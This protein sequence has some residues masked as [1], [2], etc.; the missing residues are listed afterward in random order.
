MQDGGTRSFASLGPALRLLGLALLIAA[1]QAVRGLWLSLL[2]IQRGGAPFAPALAGALCGLAA[3]AAFAF[4]LRHA[5]EN[6]QALAGGGKL[7]PPLALA[8]L[9]QPRLEHPLRE[10]WARSNPAEAGAPMPRSRGFGGLLGAGLAIAV[11]LWACGLL[12]PLAG[13]VVSALDAVHHALTFAACVAGLHFAALLAQRQDD[14]WRQVKPSVLPVPLRV[15]GKARAQPVSPQSLPAS[16][17]ARGPAI[18]ARAV[19]TSAAA[20]ASSAPP[21]AISAPPPAISAP[22]PPPA[23]ARLVE[24]PAAPPT[25]CPI[26]GA[27]LAGRR[28]EACG[29]PALAASFRVLRSLGGGGARRTYLAEAP[30]G[31]RVVL[32]ELSIATAPDAQALDGFAREAR[33][34]RE[35]RHP[36]LPIYLDAFQEEEG[37]RARLYLAYRYLDGISLQQELEERR[38]SEDEVLELVEQVLEILRHLHCL[39][40]PLIHRDLKPANLVRRRDGAISLIDFGVARSLDRT[41]NSG[42]LAGT[43]G[44]M[45]PEQLAGQVDLTSDLYALGATALH[46]LTRTAPWEFMDGPELRLPR[47]PSAPVARALLRRM[48]APRRAQRFS[49]AREALVALRRLRAGGRRWPRAALAGAG[50]AAAT[51]GLVFSGLGGG[52]PVP[53]AEQGSAKVLPAQMVPRP[54]PVKLAAVEGPLIWWRGGSLT[55][56]QVQETLRKLPPWLKSDTPWWIQQHV[57]ALVRR[58]LLAA[59]AEKRGLS[60]DLLAGGDRERLLAAAL[61]EREAQKGADWDLARSRREAWT[62]LTSALFAAAEVHYDDARLFRLEPQKLNGPLPSALSASGEPMHLEVMAPAGRCLIEVEPA[63]RRYGGRCEGAPSLAQALLDPETLQLVDLSPLPE[64]FAAR[65]TNDFVDARQLARGEGLEAAKQAELALIR[66]ELRVAEVTGTVSYA[67]VQD[68]LTSVAPALR[69][70]LAAALQES[71]DRALRARIRF[72]IEVLDGGIR[73]ARLEAKPNLPAALCSQAL[74]RPGLL[75]AGGFAVVGDLERAAGQPGR[76]SAK[77]NDPGGD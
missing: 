1:A 69:R 42:T 26:C 71:P 53:V 33:M 17:S 50:V 10:L 31:A 37:P 47:L 13:R 25:A 74:A 20:A 56:A 41:V 76:T 15:V 12:V 9:L 73:S 19:E 57:L 66:A 64:G 29:A 36:K 51:V 70:C 5:D 30:D 43:V 67:Q 65:F 2:A 11:P 77:A 52:A 7:L 24:V 46:L 16:R 58:K 18:S 62:R 6:T 35:L 61:L 28:C 75:G 54:P 23:E 27:K 34:L 59:E 39:Q 14:A 40:P 44:Y 8:R 21:A 22:P 3:I 72:Q 48:L 32:K 38:Y 68:L 55:T 63:L 4:F 60:A 45:P 49:S